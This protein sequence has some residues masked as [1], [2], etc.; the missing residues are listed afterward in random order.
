VGVVVQDRPGELANLFAAVADWNVNVE[1]IHV[2]H[3][4]NAPFGR[5]ELAVAAERATELVEQ[6]EG[7]GWVAYRRS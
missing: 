3:S 1:D 7:A 5:L 2:E 4:R 6:L